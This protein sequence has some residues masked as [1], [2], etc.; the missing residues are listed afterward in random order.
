MLYE[1][2]QARRHEL[3]AEAKQL[4]NRAAYEEVRKLE[5]M[6]RSV[7]VIGARLG[8]TPVAAR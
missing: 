5:R 6:Q 1:I 8:L 3:I 4:T 2:A 7:R